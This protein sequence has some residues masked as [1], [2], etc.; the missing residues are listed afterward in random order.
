LGRGLASRKARK[1]EKAFLHSSSLAS[2]IIA[3]IPMKAFS[4]IDENELLRQIGLNPEHVL[5]IKCAKGLLIL[6]KTASLTDL[7][8]GLI[9]ATDREWHEEEYA[10]PLL[11]RSE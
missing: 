1:G 3:V 8:V 11:R 7:L 5:V 6:D 10:E 4:E 9:P 2:T